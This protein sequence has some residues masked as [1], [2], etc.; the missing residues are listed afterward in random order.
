M[1]SPSLPRPGSKPVFKVRTAPPSDLQ[2]GFRSS[3]FQLWKVI[4]FNHLMLQVEAGNLTP[5]YSRNLTACLN[6]N[7]VSTQSHG[8][9]ACNSLCLNTAPQVLRAPFVSDALM[10]VTKVAEALTCRCIFTC[11]YC[12]NIQTQCLI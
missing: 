8:S 3:P 10:D 5:K 4:F 12:T 9:T 6:K 7:N 1:T 2:T 11:E